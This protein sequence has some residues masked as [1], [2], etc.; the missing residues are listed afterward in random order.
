MTRPPPAASICGTTTRAT[1]NDPVIFVS[2]TS[3]KPFGETSHVSDVQL[4]PDRRRPEVRCDHLGAGAGSAYDR[5]AGAGVDE[6]LSH[7][8]SQSAGGAGYQDSGAAEVRHV[9][10]VRGFPVQRIAW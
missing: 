8:E 6:R 7:S 4:E 10:S 1:R 5:D 2:I 3:R 9:T